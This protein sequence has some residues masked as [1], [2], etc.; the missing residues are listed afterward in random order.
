M[1][2]PVHP[3]LFGAIRPG[4]R[5]SVHPVT[6]SVQV[7]CLGAV[8]ISDSWSVLP[9][10]D[11]VQ[12]PCLG[13]VRVDVCGSVHPM[14]LPIQVPRLGAVRMGDVAFRGGREGGFPGSVL[15]LG[16]ELDRFMEPT[17][18]DKFMS[19]D[20]HPFFRREL[21]FSIMVWVRHN[22]FPSKQGL[23]VIPN[24]GVDG[25]PGWRA[26]GIT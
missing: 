5:W 19:C 12:E 17:I 2:F 15:V 1:Q 26:G 3:I 6:L 22:G 18:S 24:K 9:V 25:D 7:P 23:W 4:D 11:P 10:T 14:T 16:E 21:P 13:A 8:Q 20:L